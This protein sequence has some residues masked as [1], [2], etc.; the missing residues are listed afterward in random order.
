MC[1]WLLLTRHAGIP[2]DVGISSDAMT[3]IS[4][5]LDFIVFGVPRS[6]TK[7]LVRALN[8]HP[9]VYCAMERFHFRTDHSRLTFPDSFLDKSLPYHGDPAKIERIRQELSAKADIQH[10]GNKL[11]RYYFALDR[12]NREVPGLLNIWIYRSPYGFMPSW[13]RREKGKESG[14]WP[15]GQIGLFG[16]L[17]LLVCIENCL[18]LRKDVFIFPYAHGLGHSPDIILE[19][20]DFLGAETRLYDQKLFERKQQLQMSKRG[21]RKTG[22]A[23]QGLSDYEEELLNTLQIK[24][25]DTILE[26]HR[27]LL[28]S[29]IS[30]LLEDYLASIAEILPDAID[31]AF[32]ACDNAAM[33][34]Y[35]WEY[36]KRN[37]AELQGLRKLTSGSTT[38]AGFQQSGL[39]QRLRSLYVQ[40]WTLKHRLAALWPSAA[41]SSGR[42][43]ERLAPAPEARSKRSWI[44]AS[45]E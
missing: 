11:P 45:D 15:A 26:R 33:T 36:F 42:T 22:A 7:G 31:R 12:I 35:G 32:K 44:R 34:S 4:R 9:H 3:V 29:E 21:Q 20:L 23:K 14:Q 38:I 13:N 18:G 40:R 27:A 10:A 39:F 5:P 25:L 8:L 24:E 28:V 1:Y 17:E 19:A 41:D 2:Y 43:R 30:S 16:L 37:R 6:G